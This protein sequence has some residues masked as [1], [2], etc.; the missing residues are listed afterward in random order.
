MTTVAVLGT[1]LM[2]A[3]MARSM[4]RAGLR[5]NAWNRT[6][7][8][9]LPLEEAGIVVA[10]EPEAAVRDADVIVTMLFDGDTVEQSMRRVLDAGAVPER[11][12]WAQCATVGLDGVERL[13]RLAESHGIA[14][15]DSPVLGT[16]QPAE[17]GALT[18]FAGGP[19]AVRETVTPVFDAIGSR[20]VW[21][22]EQPGSGHRLKLA[23]NAWVLTVTAAT[24]QSVG[25]AGRL[26]VDPRLFLEAIAGGALDCTYAQ[27]KGPAM[28][29][30]DFT[31]AFSLAGAIKDATLVE[32]A[33]QAAG[34]NG[35]LMRALRSA[36]E[37]AARGVDADGE[38]M[39]A[40]IRA[41]A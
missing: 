27:L 25:L 37:A 40:V 30:G 36:Y 33:A 14:F 23:A 22:G 12:V 21:V 20:T 5:V 16:R 10:R 26:G 18:V 9:A 41:F 17:N 35:E 8:K 24:A 2:G 15:V 13:A 7:E 29:E 6:L 32:Q 3:G 28:I 38:D 34:G 39:A 4:A 11:A 19:A 1:G 31:P